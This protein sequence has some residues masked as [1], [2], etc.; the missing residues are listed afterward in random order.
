M[1]KN[2]ILEDARETDIWG[3]YDVIVVGGGPAGIAASVASRRSG[4]KTLLLERYGFL[5]G[6]AT[7]G[8]VGSFCGFFTTGPEKKLVV[9]GAAGEILAFLNERNGLSDKRVSFVDPRIAVYQYSPEV[10]KFAADEIVMNHGVD[11]LLHTL[12]VDLIREKQTRDTMA[13]HGMACHLSGVIIEN[14]SGRYACMGKVIIDATG[15]G[16]IAFKAGA[17]YDSG[18]EKG[19]FQSMTTIF[20]MVNIHGD[21]LSKIIMSDV[22]NKMREARDTGAYDFPRIGAVMGR[23]IPA[24]V[25]NANVTGIPNLSPIDA[26]ELSR[27]EIEGRRQ[28]FEYLRFFQDTLPGFEKAE[29]STIA[30]Q[31]GVR[32]TRRIRGSYLLSENEVLGGHKHADTIALG[33]WPVE[34]HNPATGNIDWRF[35]DNDDDYYGI[36]MGCLTPPEIDNLI[37]AGRCIS[38]THIAQAS[39]RVIAQAFALGEAAGVIASMAADKASAGPEASTNVKGTVSDIPVEQVRKT[40]IERG[41]I[42][43]V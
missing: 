11:V 22:N 43:E 4:A 23:A 26:A 6:T 31:A 30:T 14:K 34:I 8:M 13:H 2:T 33:A 40:L 17:A 38:T 19:I 10:L 1:S 9:S 25:V 20:R 36:P 32:E 7:A 28:V 21:A 41:A 16:D 27:A 37:V 42:L 12:V 35:L 24:G 15:D 39:T 29:V 3:N 5:G 18:D